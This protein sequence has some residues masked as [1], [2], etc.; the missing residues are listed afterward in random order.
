MT[1]IRFALYFLALLIGVGASQSIVGYND[2]DLALAVPVHRHHSSVKGSETRLAEQSASNTAQSDLNSSG[3][4][5]GTSTSIVQSSLLSNADI[6]QLISNTFNELLAQGKLK[7]DPGPQGPPGAKG[8]TGSIQNPTTGPGYSGLTPYIITPSPTAYSIPSGVSLFAATDLSGE[9]VTGKDITAT[10]SLTVNG[11]ATI[12]GTITG[13]V[14]GSV[15][16][17]FTAG[18]VVFQGA[19]GLA[20]D[21]AN[22]FYDVTNHRLGIGTTSPSSLLHVVGSQPAAVGGAG[23]AATQVIQITG[24]KGGNTTGTTG[25]TA[26]SGAAVNVT[27]GL[28]G[29]AP[30]GSTNA[31]GANITLQG[32]AP[33]AG[34]GTAGSYGNILLATNG[35]RVGIGNTANPGSK[36]TL[37]TDAST[38]SGISVTSQFASNALN[39]NQSGQAPPVA[40]TDSS[41]N[42]SIEITKT[43]SA[44]TANSLAAG[45]IL[46][47]TYQ[48]SGSS[49]LGRGISITV[50]NN[51]GSS[52]ILYGANISATANTAGATAVGLSVSVASTSGTA[53]AATFQGGNVGIGTTT[54]GSKLDIFGD[55]T[56]NAN[57]GSSYKLQ[58][59]NTTGTQ[60]IYNR[61]YGPSNG[62]VI[63]AGGADT[64]FFNQD[65]QFQASSFSTSGAYTSTSGGFINNATNPVVILNR[66]ASTGLG[67]IFWQTAS[68]NKWTFGLRQN[69]TGM[70]LFDEVAGASRLYVADSSG[71]VGIGTTTQF[72]SGTGVIGLANAGTDPTTNPTGG[73]V[74][75]ASSG[76]LKWRGSSGT[77]TQLAAA[78]YAEDMP[79]NDP[80]LS[81][82]EVVSVS[83][84]PNPTG[85]G[86]YNKFLIE[87]ATKPY[88]SHLLGVVSSFTDLDKPPATS[89]PVALVGRVP[90]KVSLENGAIAVGDYLTASG[91]RPGYAMKAMAAGFVIGKALEATS[92]E[93]QILVFVNP[94]YYIPSVA[95]IL[96]NNPSQDLI[97]LNMTNASAFDKLV[98]TDT[99]YVGAKLIV[100]GTIQAKQINTDK[101]CVG[102]VCVTQEQFL[103]MVEQSNASDSPAPPVPS[104]DPS[105]LP[106]GP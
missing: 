11:S 13:S 1:H 75:Y 92:T 90:V 52:G 60:Y 80:S 45:L 50:T 10:H 22:F 78:D 102:T 98:V 16:P 71:N 7:G 9:R 81:S 93:G 37:I 48:H 54:P 47:G 23:T 68:A 33:G 69:E 95:T 14:S 26:G 30:S 61:T 65:G 57:G 97:D 64:F 76:A 56:V 74:L 55:T 106:L 105:T 51:T 40:I 82:A 94:T 39:I 62:I 24:G 103:K 31:N 89:R 4:V 15:N 72:G 79:T 85:D 20:Q 25:Q 42:G 83:P 5:L 36:L 35:G 70:N 67:R 53:Y 17:G 3:K 59:T 88:D 32:G 44:V 104:P 77:V 27:A 96:Q 2:Q 43:T 12:T 21:N 84:I 87:R 18:S 49:G 63:S 91:T 38:P 6:A 8:D 28:G 73:G 46:S 34:A 66:S 100:N 101:L 86:P 99:L 41:F 58:L 29:D 19:S